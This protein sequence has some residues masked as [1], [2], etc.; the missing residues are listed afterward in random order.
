MKDQGRRAL[1]F[2]SNALSGTVTRLDLRISGDGDGDGDERVTVASA[3]QIASGT[4]I[5]ATRRPSWWGRRAS[6]SMKGATFCTSP[7]PG[8]TPYSRSAMPATRDVT[9]VAG[10]SWS[11]T[12]R[13]FTDR[14][15]SSLRPT[16]IWSR[17]RATPSIPTRIRTGRARSSSSQPGGV[18]RAVLGRTD[19]RRC[20]LRG[21][22][23][24][25]GQR[26]PVCRGG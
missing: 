10:D 16:A 18:R 7:R 12:R 19:D 25:P 11:T 8:T 24:G 5:A 3:T 20:G 1:V 9:L 4:R 15:G 17:R 6:P 14:S 2:V 23:R 22:D 21:R 26:L 13:T